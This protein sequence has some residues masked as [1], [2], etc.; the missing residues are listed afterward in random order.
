M[1]ARFFQHR[2]TKIV[3][4]TGVC[5]N[6]GLWIRAGVNLAREETS[7]ATIAPDSVYLRGI[8]VGFCIGFFPSLIWPISLPALYCYHLGRTEPSFTLNDGNISIRIGY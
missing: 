7:N 5:V 8:S 1:L 3:Y 4:H 6:L 2:A